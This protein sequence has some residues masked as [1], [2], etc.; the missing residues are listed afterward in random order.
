MGRA[1]KEG[2]MKFKEGDVLID[3]HG[4]RYKVTDVRR[5]FTPYPYRTKCIAGERV[6]SICRFGANGEYYGTGNSGSKFDVVLAIDY[7]VNQ[8]WEEYD[9]E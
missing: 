8:M 9:N 7:I 1:G 4:N 6:G 2:R 3:R 5:E